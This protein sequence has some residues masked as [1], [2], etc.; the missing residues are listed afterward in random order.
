MLH[1]W[2][3]INSLFGDLEVS[4]G[5]SAVVLEHGSWKEGFF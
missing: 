4:V 3:Q 2:N 1:E 5:P